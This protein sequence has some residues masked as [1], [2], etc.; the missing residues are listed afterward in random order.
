MQIDTSEREMAELS[1]APLVEA[2]IH[3]VMKKYPGQSPAALARYF[4]A[5]H[6]ELAPLARELERENRQLREQLGFRAKPEHG[7][8]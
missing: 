5:V 1:Q 2:C 6:Q 8:G 4:E 3:R 7:E